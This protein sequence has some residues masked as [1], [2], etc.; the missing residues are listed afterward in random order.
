MTGLSPLARD[1]RDEI[2]TDVWRTLDL[3]AA[4]CVPRRDIETGL[5]EL[6]LA[7]EPILGGPHG[8][9]WTND[10]DELARY[11]ASRRRRELSVARGTRA[12]MRT[13]RRL[14]ERTD[15]TLFGST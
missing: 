2:V 11:V 5:E 14:R 12:L 6:R 4:L 7:G 10:P 13:A 8:V 1:L 15:L 3:A 9:R